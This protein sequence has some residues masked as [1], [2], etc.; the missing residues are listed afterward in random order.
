VASPRQVHGKRRPPAPRS[1]NR[2]LT[3]ESLLSGGFAH[4]T[5]PDAPFCSGHEP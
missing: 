1:K 3:N 2:D 4:P 5:F